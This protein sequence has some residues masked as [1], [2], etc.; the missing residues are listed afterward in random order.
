MDGDR[1]DDTGR[2]RHAARRAHRPGRS[3]Q[4]VALLAGE[5]VLA[6][7]VALLAGL[8]PQPAPPA[9]VSGAFVATIGS[10]GKIDTVAVEHYTEAADSL[11]GESVVAYPSAM[12]RSYAVEFGRGGMVRHIHV[13]T[14][15]P[16]AAPT[17][18]ADYAY[19]ADS[20]VVQLR[21][22]TLSRRLAVAVTGSQPLPFYEDLFAFWELSV[23]SAMAGKADTAT[24]GALAGRGVLP[25]TFQRRSAT[26]ADFGFTDWGTV[27]AQLNAAHRFVRLD[28]TGTT[29]KYIV[30]RVPSVDVQRLA[31][32]WAARPQPG[33]LSPRD[34]A[35]ADVGAAHVVVDYGRP[36]MRGRKVF[37]GIVPW[38][39]VWRTGANAA[40]QLIT[41]HD[42]VIGD[43]TL[44]AGT[45]SL[46]SLP[47]ADGWT[48]IINKQHGQWGTEYHADRDFARIPLTVTHP[49]DS[50]EQFTIAV[51]ATGADT[52]TL[53]FAWEKT[54]GTVGFRVK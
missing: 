38:D 25:I 47:T 14:G 1:R 33:Q 44:P 22:D 31:M 29:N 45:Y 18:I 5:T 52:G 35:R 23:G 28:M 53:A 39:Q 46:F 32:A 37:G 8:A 10:G 36:S 17:T 9:P 11:V 34:T 27:H 3:G 16:G 40:T 20:V 51:T 54:R 26:S 4:L 42:L 50:V 49:S 43:T 12:A 41:D 15:R 13:A 6:G 30:E 48:L 2:L 19:S 21:R 7:A 24:L